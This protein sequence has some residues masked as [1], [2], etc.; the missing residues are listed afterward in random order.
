MRLGWSAIPNLMRVGALLSSFMAAM[1]LLFVPLS[2]FDIGSYSINERVVTGP[3]FLTHVYPIIAPHLG[4]LVA[5]AYGI[6]TERTWV[7]PLAM[8]FWVAVDLI[9]VYAVLV[10]LVPEAETVVYALWA[11]VYIAVVWW[12]FYRKATVIAYYRALASASR[13]S[14]DGA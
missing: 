2:A 6:W 13:S 10:G 1:F 7:R 12:Y 9:L 3:Y 5:I 11:V 4:L 14:T 8:V